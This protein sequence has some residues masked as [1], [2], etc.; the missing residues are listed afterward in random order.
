MYVLVF[1]KDL[2]KKNL[3]FKNIFQYREFFDISLKLKFQCFY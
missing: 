3:K 2:Y 1:I